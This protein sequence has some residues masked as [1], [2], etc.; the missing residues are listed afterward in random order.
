MSPFKGEIC[1]HIQ[2]IST[3]YM[4]FFHLYFGELVQIFFIIVCICLYL[5]CCWRS[6]YQDERAGI[7][8]TGLTLPHFCA[9]FKC[10][11]QMSYVIVF[12][13]VLSEWVQLRW[14]L[15]VSFVVIGGIVDHLCLTFYFTIF[16]KCFVGYL[17]QCLVNFTTDMT[18]KS[19]HGFLFSFFKIKVEIIQF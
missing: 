10:G 16:N 15:I 7:P 9:C 18:I 8:L 2:C 17:N 1:G 14:E 19:T 12:F 13:C 4:H 11:V 5:Y 3:I 6:S